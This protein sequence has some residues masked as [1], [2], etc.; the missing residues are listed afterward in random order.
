MIVLGDL[1]VNFLAPG[2]NK[3]L[4][5]VFELFGFRQIIEKPNE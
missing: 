1:N 2:G 3:D 4:K 5:S